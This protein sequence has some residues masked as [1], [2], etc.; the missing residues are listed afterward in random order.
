MAVS[1][2]T[3]IVFPL[4]GRPLS[5]M[6]LCRALKITQIF[7]NLR[8][9]VNSALQHQLDANVGQL[10]CTLFCN[11]FYFNIRHQCRVKG[12]NSK[13]LEHFAH[14]LKDV[15]TYKTTELFWRLPERGRNLFANFLKFFFTSLVNFANSNF[16]KLII[17][18]LHNLCTVEC[19]GLFWSRDLNTCKAGEF[20]L[21]T[22]PNT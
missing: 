13:K 1:W 14:V 9:N 16:A 20:K 15:F 17:F 10:F 22:N 4:K 21:D 11:K 7:E 12:V 2:N 5:G 18:F 8:K 3:K 6:P 19:Y